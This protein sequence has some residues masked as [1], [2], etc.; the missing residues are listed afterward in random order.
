MNAYARRLVTLAV[1]INYVDRGNLSTA[2]PLIQRELR[3][4]PSELGLLFSAFYWGYVP[5]VPATGWLAERFGSKTVLGA[6][7]GV[8]SVATLLTGISSTFT[9]LIVL[10]VLLGVGE[11]VAFPCASSIFAAVVSVEHLGIA[12]GIMSF[13]YLLGPAI[14]TFAGGHL[15]SMAGWRP[16]FAIFGL[17]SLSWLLPWRRT[18]VPRTA[19][20]RSSADSPRIVDLIKQ[21]ALWGTCLGHF[22]S[23]YAYY[24]IISWLPY[25]QVTTRGFS[26]GSMASIA[27]WAYL[28][29]A[30]TASAMGVLSDHWI[31]R[32]GSPTVIYKGTMAVAH[33]ASVACMIGMVS[34]PRG[35][36]I[37]SLFIFEAISGCSY[38]GLFAIP[39]ILAGPRA[40]GRWVGIQNAAGNVAGLIAPS[41]TGFLVQDSGN[42]GLAF[43]LSALISA[44]GIVGWVV[45]LPRIEPQYPAG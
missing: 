45:L 39:Q 7:L 16:V 27:G 1:F 11:S 38:P 21:R 10:R 31:R 36:S 26:Y 41:V 6:G 19:R 33:A 4:T 24:F 30:S 5:L 23:N 42:F 15:M 32:G 35:G 12:N 18:P 43:A 2:A 25:Y 22:S 20:Q 17:I 44:L 28:L 8:W 3:L 14:G 40:S 34:L 37:A 13:E 29:N 9:V